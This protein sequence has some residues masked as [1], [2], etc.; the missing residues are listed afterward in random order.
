MLID[1]HNHTGWG[2][3]D[4][5]IDPSDL[6]EQARR[7]GLDGIAVTDHDQVWDPEKVEMLR[8]RHRFP[9]LGG[10]EVDTDGGHVLVFGLPGPQRWSRL[11][12]VEQLRAAVDEAG[13]VMVLAH[14]FQDLLAAVLLDQKSDVGLERLIERY[15]WG[16]VD[17]IEV[18]NGRMGPQQRELAA[19]LAR[20]L[21]LPTT[22][23][24]D[25]HR[26]MEVARSFTV[27]DDEIRDEH[28][29]VAA[30]KAGRC[31]GGDW[32]AE[33]LFDKRGWELTAA[34]RNLNV[35]SSEE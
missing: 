26:L 21:N 19:E 13:G 2:S 29:L 6:I 23:G 28:E 7:W 3:G 12:T 32:S 1:L 16:L 35:V 30:I 8:R 10:V 31:H 33:G 17:A 25:T 27:F 24:S 15:R 4:S 11:P 9:V 34:G 18:Y 20:R 14:P 5:H 22:G